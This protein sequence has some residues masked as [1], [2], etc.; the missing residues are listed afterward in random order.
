MLRGGQIQPT[1][2]SEI[3]GKHPESGCLRSACTFAALWYLNGA[4]R[5][6]IYTRTLVV[7]G[8]AR[9][10]AGPGPRARRQGTLRA[11]AAPSCQ[12]RAPGGSCAWARSTAAPRGGQVDEGKKKRKARAP[13][14]CQE[15]VWANSRTLGRTKKN[16]LQHFWHA[17]YGSTKPVVLN[18]QA[19]VTRK[20]LP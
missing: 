10:P 5:C 13:I 16:P 4:R 12:Q 18:A 15:R 6:E 3:Q 20:C 2:H 7:W 8:S 17:A 11:G 19:N 9:R 1:L 14:S